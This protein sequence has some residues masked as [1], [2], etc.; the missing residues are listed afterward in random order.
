MNFS[1]KTAKQN[2][3]RACALFLLLRTRAANHNKTNSMT[4]TGQIAT[5]FRA[6]HFGGNWTA[7]HLKEQLADVTWQQATARVHSFNPIGTLVFHL[8]YYVS[9]V[10]RVLRGGPLDAHDKHSFH[11]PPIRSQED[12]EKL[13]D[14][15]WTDAEA[16]ARLV[17]Q[18][19]EETLWE[20]FADG[21]YGNYYRNL[22][23]P[24]EHA[25]YHLGQIVLIKKLLPAG[26]S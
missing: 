25:H 2:K 4:L 23:G 10:S 15:T 16:F 14:Q 12:W 1:G 21:K 7:V 3:I 26:K 22:H 20:P 5:H 17:E 11:H 6:V 13:L 24:V 9:A 19:P 18:L 8:N